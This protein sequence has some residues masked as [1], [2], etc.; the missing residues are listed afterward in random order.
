MQKAVSISLTRLHRSLVMRCPHALVRLLICVA[1]LSSA[2]GLAWLRPEEKEE[3]FKPLFNGRDFAGWRFSGGKEDGAS[4]APNWKVEEGVIR[5]SGGGSPHLAT[6]RE[7]ADF[8]LRFEWRAL[9]DNYNSGLFV[10]SGHKVNANQINLAKG[11]EGSFI[12][13]KIEGARAVPQLQKPVNEWNEWRVLAQGDRLT[14]WCNGEKAWE[15]TGLKPA[16]GYI[17]LQA[18]GALIEFRKLRIREIKE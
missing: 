17:G 13:G 12:G 2:S 18:E 1:L 15:A 16:K 10:R 7:Y 11:R 4:E 5:L 8:E 9:R 6:E 14:F 3:G